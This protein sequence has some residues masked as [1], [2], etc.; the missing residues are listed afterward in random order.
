MFSKLD[1]GAGN[2]NRMTI[3]RHALTA[4]QQCF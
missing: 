1:K 4:S 2:H 3:G